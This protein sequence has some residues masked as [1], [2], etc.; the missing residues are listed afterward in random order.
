MN[1]PKII[2]LPL[3]SSLLY[4]V[5]SVLQ[6]C[7]NILREKQS[8][9]SENFLISPQSH[10]LFPLLILDLVGALNRRIDPWIH[11]FDCSSHTTIFPQE[12]IPRNLNTTGAERIGTCWIASSICHWKWSESNIQ[13][14]IITII[15]KKRSGVELWAVGQSSKALAHSLL[16][17]FSLLSWVRSFRSWLDTETPRKSYPRLWVLSIMPKIPEIS[18]GIQMK[19]LFQFL[20]T[21]IFGITSGGGPLISVAI[22]RSKFAVPFLTNRFFVLI[23]EFGNDKKSGKSYSYWLTWFNRKMSFH[24]PWVVPLISDRWVWHNGK[25]PMIRCPVWVGLIVIRK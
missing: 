2:F 9:F 17:R 4:L 5:N 18:V 10:F 11:N 1:L 19:R 7:Q 15:P 3:Q 13:A 23:R 8:Y 16:L 21:G 6:N 12:W 24:L 14:S 22:F 20:P 25:Q